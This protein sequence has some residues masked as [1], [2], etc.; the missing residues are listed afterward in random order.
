MKWL[1]I[2]LALLAA[3]VITIVLI[4]SLLPKEHVAARTARFKTTP[5]Q[6]FA[7]LTDV[8]AFPSWRNVRSVQLVDGA[9]GRRAWREVDS[10]GQAILF[11]V[12]EEA[13]PRLLVS[14]IADPSLPFGG[15]WTY[16][17][18]ELP[19]GGSEVTI[20]ENGEVRNPIFRF[21]SRFILGHTAT[22]D[23]FLRALGRKF[24]EPVSLTEA[25]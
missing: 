6:I 20:T 2:V 15:T 11:E 25:T 3:L 7:A 1:L 12:M 13:P 10:H 22:M 5:Q 24:G 14:R 17:I 8:S 18:R 23:E 16:E 19:G 9:A 21:V 4:G